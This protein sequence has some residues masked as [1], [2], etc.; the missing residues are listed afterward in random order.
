[1]PER[2][3]ART[4]RHVA[5][6]AAFRCEYCQ[7]PSALSPS[8]YSAE[9]ILP[10]RRG[11]TNRP[12]NLALSCQGCNGHK[13]V[14]TAALDPATGR[15]V[16]VFNPRKQMWAEH[17]VWAEGGMRIEGVTACGRATVAALQLNRVGLQNLRRLM[18]LAEI[19]PADQAK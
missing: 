18:L 4:R 11:G 16:P 9:H 13:G 1:M 6:R 17:F 5:E 19:H 10:R 14:R 15:T 3:D 7:T 2:L 12:E 8:P